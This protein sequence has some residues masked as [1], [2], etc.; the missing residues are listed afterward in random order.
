MK[1]EV[2]VYT[3][4]KSKDHD[5]TEWDVLDITTTG[6]L[7]DKEGV[8]YLIYDEYIGD[9][10]DDLVHNRI[11]IGQDPLSVQVTKSGMISTSFLYEENGEDVVNYATPYGSMIIRVNTEKIELKDDKEE[12]KLHLEIVYK[13]SVNGDHETDHIIFIDTKVTDG[14]TV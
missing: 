3:I 11:K 5:Q 7:Y 8:L 12:G 9:S 10:E 6:Y 2:V 4:G 13:M 1:K 14:R